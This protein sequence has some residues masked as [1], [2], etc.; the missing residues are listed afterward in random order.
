MMR[1]ARAMTRR[2]GGC[3]HVRLKSTLSPVQYTTWVPD[4]GKQS[5]PLE[6]YPLHPMQDPAEV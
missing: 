2:P 1:S 3:E 4:S 6:G 5:Q